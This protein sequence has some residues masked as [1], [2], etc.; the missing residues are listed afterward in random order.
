MT[1]AACPGCVPGSGRGQILWLRLAACWRSPMSWGGLG[2]QNPGLWLG[3]GAWRVVLW[4]R[5]ALWPSGAAL[6]IP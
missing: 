1:L 6:A 3:W 5:G 2:G 4:L